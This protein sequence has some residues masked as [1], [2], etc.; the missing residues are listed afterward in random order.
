MGGAIGGSGGRDVKAR[1]SVHVLLE[2]LL[3]DGLMVEPLDE[4][5]FLKPLP[6]LLQEVSQRQ[7]RLDQHLQVLKFIIFALPTFPCFHL[8]QAP[9]SY[10]LTS[11][12]LVGRQTPHQDSEGGLGRADQGLGGQVADTSMVQ[13]PLAPP[14]RLTSSRNTPPCTGLLR[15]V[16]T[17]GWSTVLVGE[18][19]L[20]KTGLVSEVRL[21]DISL[22]SFSDPGV[23]LLVHFCK[24]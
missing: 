8:V 18:V 7:L 15:D 2:V 20:P 13:L 14:V 24:I 5:L 22:V 4:E 3:C 17:G 10:L 9:L 21:R 19:R 6:L 12:L 16:F 11:L 23:L 1:H